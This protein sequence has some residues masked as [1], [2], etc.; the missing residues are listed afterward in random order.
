MRKL[1]IILISL[2]IAVTAIVTVAVIESVTAS[3]FGVTSA[4]TGTARGLFAPFVAWAKDMW[5]V[6]GADFAYMAAT[7]L[8]ISIVGGLFMVFIAWGLFWQKLIKGKLL[9]QVAPAP[10]PQMQRTIST[11][12]QAAPSEPQSISPTEVVKPVKEET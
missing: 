8:S 11:Q 12:I 9:H 1:A 3:D 6:I 4:V 10:A 5:L 7:V 2:L